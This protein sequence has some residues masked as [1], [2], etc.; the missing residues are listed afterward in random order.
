MVMGKRQLHLQQHHGYKL[1]LASYLHVALILLVQF[2]VGMTLVHSMFPV[3]IH[4]MVS[5][6][7]HDICVVYVGV[8][9]VQARLPHQ[10]VPS[11]RYR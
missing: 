5:I 10:Q 3:D 4:G 8:I 6:T 2:T 9:L 7:V 1:A 11:H